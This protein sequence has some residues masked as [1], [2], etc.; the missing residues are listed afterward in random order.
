MLQLVD[1]L[2]NGAVEAE[3]GT[4]D[5]KGLYKAM[6]NLL[7]I[8]K[9]FIIILLICLTLKCNFSGRW[10]GLVQSTCRRTA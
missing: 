9:R 1:R 7:F 10:K 3:V 2:D 6:L 5:Y 4:L 8:K